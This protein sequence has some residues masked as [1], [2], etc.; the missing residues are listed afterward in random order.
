MDPFYFD[1]VISSCEYLTFELEIYSFKFQVNTIISVIIYNFYKC[2]KFENRQVK[3]SQVFVELYVWGNCQFGQLG[4][5]DEY[6][7]QNVN[8][9][10]CCSYKIIVVKIACGFQHSCL[11]VNNGSLY[12]MGLN[13]QGQLGLNTQLSYIST[14]QLIELKGP[15]IR[16]KAAANYTVAQRDTGELYTWGQNQAFNIHTNQ[17]QLLKIK[18]INQFS[19]G[20]H[21]M[22]LIDFNCQL[23]MC[24][25]NDYGQLGLNCYESFVPQ[26]VLSLEKYDKVKCG[27]THTLVLNNGQV[28][29]FGSNKTGEL[30]NGKQ[31]HSYNQLKPLKIQNVN[32]IYASNFSAAI[33]SKNELY[34][35]GSGIFGEFLV[36][37]KIDFANSIKKI[38]LGNGFGCILDDDGQIYSWGKNSSGELAQ[39]DFIP[40]TDIQHIKQLKNKQIKTFDC[41]SNFVVCISQIQEISINYDQIIKENDQLKQKLLQ[42]ETIFKNQKMKSQA[43]LQYT[44]QQ[45]CKSFDLGIIQDQLEQKQKIIQE[46]EKI[47]QSQKDRIIFLESELYYYQNKE[48][49]NENSVTYPFKKDVKNQNKLTYDFYNQ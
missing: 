38:K 32:K 43:D 14:P 11:L 42:M 45:E 16:V 35:W 36:P 10:K 30:G 33:T 39:K 21:H 40:R 44:M 4:L 9:P 27:L 34:L 20:E 5:G 48:N 17:P 46:Q 24:G 15:F 1:L 22:G 49:L 18:K 2:L 25:S 29:S 26:Q 6:L 31:Q 19:C 41:G 47:I 7:K 37:T 8:N 28:Y 12:T 3:L 13:E 23:Y